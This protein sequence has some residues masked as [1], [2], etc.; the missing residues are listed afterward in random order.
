MSILIKCDVCGKIIPQP[1]RLPTDWSVSC[2]Y[3]TSK[4]ERRTFVRMLHSCPTCPLDVPREAVEDLP[5]LTLEEA[6]REVEECARYAAVDEDELK[7]SARKLLVRALSI[8]D[9]ARDRL[10]G[11]T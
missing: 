8:L 5:I 7:G 9:A 2:E 10:S 6:F 1:R 3:K 4:S 11:E